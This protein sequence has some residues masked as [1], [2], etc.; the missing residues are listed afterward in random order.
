MP[1]VA[2]LIVDDDDAMANA[3]AAAM[4]AYG[5]RARV[6]AGGRAAFAIPESW[7]PHVVILDIEMPEWDG[8]SVAKSMRGS[9]RF[10]RVPILAHTS[11]AEAEIME[12]GIEAEIDAYYRKGEPLH[13]LFRMIE[14]LAPVRYL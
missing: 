12:R 14:Y 1:P 8:F 3:L 7:V 11:L 10:A 5:C 9:I 2:V 4:M 6:A 13:G